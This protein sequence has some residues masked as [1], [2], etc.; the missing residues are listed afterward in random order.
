MRPMFGYHLPNYTF[1][2]VG[3]EALFEHVVDIARR[4]DRTIRLRDLDGALHILPFSEVTKIS[5]MTKGFAYALVDIGVA[6]DSDLEH[7]MRI[8]REVGASLQEDP[9]FKRVILEPID[10]MGVQALE[11][12]SIT[13]R[14]R[15]RTRPGQQ[16]LVRRL[17]L[18]RI[19][20][21]FDTENI[22]IP[23]P[24]I[25][26]ITKSPAAPTVTEIKN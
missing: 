2:G 15:M 14:A 23:F 26:H 3:P 17:L 1:P 7:V 6:Y 5:N 12:S 18:L 8:M 20:Q 13:I 10:V 4:A 16:W 25:T 19:N 24:T 11:A 21:R 22:E 9:V